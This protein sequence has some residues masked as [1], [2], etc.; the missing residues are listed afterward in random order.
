MRLGQ[1]NAR[2]PHLP[3]RKHVK[4]GPNC[5]HRILRQIHPGN[6]LDHLYERGQSHQAGITHGIPWRSSTGEK[7][8]N[9]VSRLVQAR[10]IRPC[11]CLFD[12]SSIL[13]FV[14]NNPDP[15]GFVNMG[16]GLQ[17]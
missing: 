12:F 17:V 15:Q 1:E 10:R 13:Q 3:Q 8:I 7:K 5:R 4:Q 2:L 9:C 14:E 16:T 11:L 6:Q